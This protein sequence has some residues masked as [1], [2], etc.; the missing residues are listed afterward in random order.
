MRRRDNELL[1]DAEQR[2][3]YRGFCWLYFI[4]RITTGVIGVWTLIGLLYVGLEW[5]GLLP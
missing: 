5:R 2:E 4:G 1:I 3:D